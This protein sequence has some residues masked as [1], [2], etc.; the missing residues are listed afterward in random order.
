MQNTMQ[1]TNTLIPMVVEKTPSGERSFDIF[2]RILKD[3]VIFINGEFNEAMASVVCAQLLFL[4]S[5]D[6]NAPITLHINSGGGCVHSG[7]A[8]R[9][10]ME[11]IS[12]DVIGI[13]TG[14]AAS[15][16]LYL[17]SCC[18][19]RAMTKRASLMAHQVSAGA[20]GNVADMRA[21]FAHTEHLNNILMSEIADNCGLS[22]NELLKIADRDRWIYSKESIKFGVVDAIYTKG[23][24]MISA[25]KEIDLFNSDGVFTWKSNR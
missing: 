23:K 11:N 6:A 7:L 25:K 1:N 5:E 15:M 10:T 14:I 12:C 17:L 8:I 24:F 16:G 3:R 13:A 21:S 4:E 18:S 20:S 19:F 2:S 9:D 22:L